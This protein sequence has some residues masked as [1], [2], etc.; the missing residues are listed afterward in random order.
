[1]Q[2]KDTHKETTPFKQNS[3]ICEVIFKNTEIFKLYL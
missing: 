2:V 3:N 1:M